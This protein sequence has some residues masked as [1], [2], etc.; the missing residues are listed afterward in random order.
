MAAAACPGNPSG[1]HQRWDPDRVI[2]DRSVVA[3]DL[4]GKRTRDGRSFNVD[5]LF[6]P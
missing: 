4:S 2:S 1:L 3:H 5:V 6:Y